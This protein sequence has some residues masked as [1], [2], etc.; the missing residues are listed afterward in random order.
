MA[1]FTIADR[2]ALA[3]RI[4]A[5]LEHCQRRRMRSL[6]PWTR[7]RWARRYQTLVEFLL[8]LGLPGEIPPKHLDGLGRQLALLEEIERDKT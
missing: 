1:E 5:V 8:V 4:F 2:D 3:T 6:A 7:I